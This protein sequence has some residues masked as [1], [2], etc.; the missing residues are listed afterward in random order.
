MTNADGA[1]EPDGHPADPRTRRA[2]APSRRRRRAGLWGVLLVTVL[3]LLATGQLLRP[4]P[5]PRLAMTAAGSYLFPPGAPLPWPSQG[6]S[7]MTVVGVGAVGTSGAQEP[8][9]I[10]GLAK[11]MTAYQVL[12]D[13]PL[14]SGEQ[15]PSITVDQK[16]VDDEKLAQA[17]GESAAP[18]TP[19]QQLSEYQALQ[20]LL[21]PSA[22]NIARLLARWDAGSETDFITRMRTTA[23]R[24]HMNATTY[25]DSS[26][27]DPITRSTARDQLRLAVA[28][29]GEPV[30]RGIVRQPNAQVAGASVHNNNDLLVSQN[31]VVGIRTGSGTAAG[32][33]LM[34]A[35]TQQVAGA[36]RLILGVVLGQRTPPVL[37]T[38]QQVSGRLISAVQGSLETL[39][40]VHRG[41]VTGYVDN[42]L[43]KR[44]TVVAARDLTVTG[45]PGL[46]VR[47]RLRPGRIP[48]KAPAGTEV[49]AVSSG[50]TS[51]PVVL[52]KQLNQPTIEERLLRI[53]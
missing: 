2:S 44:V 51:V 12:Q 42:G 16:A 4:V 34:W 48:G 47:L 32:G 26:G 8:A 5:T 24:L 28:A 1:P 13:R 45:W 49:G 52:Q 38:V 10:A 39:T 6:Q 15:G 31:G 43:G 9:P 50:R 33:C 29:M 36:E 37:T 11:V 23:T 19:G 14:K 35:A 27:L 3:A 40:L 21:L 25:T 22:N 18:V 53:G 46:K 30:F 20:L 7:A 41:E 17:A